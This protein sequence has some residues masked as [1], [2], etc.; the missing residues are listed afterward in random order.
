MRPI[1]FAAFSIMLSSQCS[2][3]GPQDALVAF[4]GALSAGDKI[5]AAEL[6]APDVTIFESGYVER[7][8]AEYVSHHLSEDIAFAKTAKRKVLKH[9]ER[10]DGKLAV[11]WE[12]TETTGVASGQ[13]IHLFG[14]ET[15]MLE[16]QGEQWKIVH[17]H[18][19]SRKAK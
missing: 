16:K 17:V 3:A 13:E 1:L 15:A 11:I 7:S 9:G 6:L 2:A 8:R 5:K 10:I 14:T 4:N 12:E 19:S 18:W